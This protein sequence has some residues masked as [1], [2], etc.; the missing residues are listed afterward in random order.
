M[1]SAN[2]ESLYKAAAATFRTIPGFK[3]ADDLARQCLD[4]AEV[5]R[6][7]AIYTHGRSEMAKNTISGYEAAI[8]Y[9]STIP[10]WDDSAEQISQCQRMIKEIK[11]REEA[12]RLE[13][14]Q[15]RITAEKKAK[16]HKI[17]ILSV[18]SIL[19]AAAAF[20]IAVITVF[21]PRKKLDEAMGLLET[22]EYEAGYQILEEIG[23]SDLIL[24]NK[25]DR[26]N[27][28]LDAE[29]Y[30]EAYALLEE[31]G[32]KKAIEKSKFHRAEA[33]NDA[34]D[35]EAAYA[36]YEELKYSIPIEQS[37][38]KRAKALIDSG[39]YEEAYLLLN[40]LTDA[41]S[42]D[43]LNS[44]LPQ[45]KEILLSQAQVGSSIFFGSYEQDNNKYNDKEPIE[46]LVLAKYGKNVLAISKYALDWKVYNHS[47]EKTDMTWQLCDLRTWL[48]GDFLNTAFTPEEQKIIISSKVSA[49]KNP[50]HLTSPGIDT[51]DKVF[52]L[53][54]AE[55]NEY[56]TS[57]AARQCQ[58]TI[59][60]NEQVEFKAEDGNIVWW[61]RT[62]GSDACYGTYVKSD[63]S[64]STHGHGV[65][66]DGAVR[67]VILMNLLP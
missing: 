49:D 21:I 13:A 42:K 11:A 22:G 47:G 56:F 5:C 45:Y 17:I 51:E 64:I 39:D 26:A 32:D 28:L 33:L 12:D 52:L 48:N 57:D 14:E 38:Y 25:Y 3:D 8:Q 66:A 65:W 2:S 37:K 19:I 53:S 62:P 29:D 63:G 35:Y 31:I 9:F 4:K 46:W 23:K 67:P 20:L 44:I 50:V 10:G 61:L 1:N 18:T 41:N 36:L 40:G 54:I 24:S 43:L 16:R 59:S 60:C 6:K 27:A 55:A 15:K 34:G 58:G 30:D 7:D